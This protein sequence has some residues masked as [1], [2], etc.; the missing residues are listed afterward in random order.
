M[1]SYE[2]CHQDLLRHLM[3]LACPRKVAAF[4]RNKKKFHFDR[5][6]QMEELAG[7]RATTADFTDSDGITYVQACT[8]GAYGSVCTRTRGGCG[9]GG[10]GYGV[11][12]PT[13]GVTLA[14]P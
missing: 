7:F 2:S 10:Y 9:V 4:T 11:E 3:P 14:E 13:R 8:R 5:T 1:S 12:F 6:L